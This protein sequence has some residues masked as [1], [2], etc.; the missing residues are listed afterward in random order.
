MVDLPF[1][2]SMRRQGSSDSVDIEVPEGFPTDLA[3]VPQPLWPLFPPWERYG[4]AALIHDYLYSRP[5]QEWPRAE[6]DRV[7]LDTM[8]SLGV[9]WFERS[10][11]FLAV[12]WF[13]GRARAAAL[14]KVP[15][16]AAT[17]ARLRE[18]FRLGEVA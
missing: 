9:R 10:A 2:A 14:G 11:I 3:S 15:L 1:K 4:P 17:Q 7:F 6:V 16:D 18:R 13:G 12:S 5:E 8:R